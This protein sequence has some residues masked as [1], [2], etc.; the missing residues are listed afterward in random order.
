MIKHLQTVLC[1]FVFVFCF[2][3][4]AYATTQPPRAYRPLVVVSTSHLAS[5]VHDLAGDLVQLRLLQ[6]PGT[7]V[8]HLALT[9]TSRDWL[10]KADLLLV[11]GTSIDQAITNKATE[12][13]IRARIVPATQARDI[14]LLPQRS[15]GLLTTQ[16]PSPAEGEEKS[17]PQ[18]TDPHWWLNAL[19]LI[20]V[21][22]LVTQELIEL[23]PQQAGN[24]QQ[25]LMLMTKDLLKLDTEW[26]QYF[27][28]LRTQPMIS[29]HDAN[30]YLTHR[31]Q[32]QEIAVATQTEQAVPP[33][34][35][36]ALQQAIE[37]LPTVCLLLPYQR[38]DLP[39]Q[40]LPE[41]FQASSRLV[42]RTPDAE[43]QNI[44]FASGWNL[45]LLQQYYRAVGDC[46]QEALKQQVSPTPAS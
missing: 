5:L 22:D 15:P 34:R 38:K 21:A 41:A 27:Q 3:H 19:N 16:P 35:L 44:A 8:H 32:L 29:W 43:G 46:L 28:A 26:N 30:A 40:P 18:T 14:A 25:R 17:S 1:F 6:R 2:C 13:H 4:D 9:P 36:A 12:L 45:S 31:F 20:A 11:H 42:T 23:L 39:A 33:R 37:S 10:D 7:D 24:I